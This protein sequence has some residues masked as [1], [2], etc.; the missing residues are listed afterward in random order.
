MHYLA[1]FLFNCVCQDAPKFEEEAT[2]IAPGMFQR[3]GT[4]KK[5]MMLFHL[6]QTT[7]VQDGKIVSIQI[8]KL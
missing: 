1:V 3:K 8:K 6:I 4:V 2:E 7:V 5:F